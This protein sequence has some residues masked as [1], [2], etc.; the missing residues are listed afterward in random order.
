V[1]SKSGRFTE[2]MHAI[3]VLQL[4]SL[5]T[6][7]V[8]IYAI[9]FMGFS[10]DYCMHAFTVISALFYVIA[11]RKSSIKFVCVIVASARICV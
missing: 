4:T 3:G 9:I 5:V 8:F 2:G 11:E 1:W 7:C 6:C 10:C